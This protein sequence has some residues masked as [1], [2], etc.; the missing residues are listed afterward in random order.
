VRC[1]LN[2]GISQAQEYDRE[3]NSALRLSILEKQ[4]V[5]GGRRS[6]IGAG[7]SFG[8]F[9]EAGLAPPAPRSLSSSLDL[10]GQSTIPTAKLLVG[11]LAPFADGIICTR[12]TSFSS[13]SRYDSCIC[14]RTGDILKLAH[15][16]YILLTV[17]EDTSLFPPLTRVARPSE[18][19]GL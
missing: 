17:S 8:V 18:P 9:E 13:R 1:M 16:T 14:E 3:M 11:F 5:P 12:S 19:I 2:I 4:L 6:R 7:V 10:L 15:D